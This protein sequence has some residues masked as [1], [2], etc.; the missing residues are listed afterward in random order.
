LVVVGAI[1]A[2]APGI[3]VRAEPAVDVPGHGEAAGDPPILTLDDAIAL[4]LEQN[5]DLRQ[6]AL[7]AEKADERLAATRSRFLPSFDLTV[8]D[9]RTIED[10]E[11][12]FPAGAFGDL[13]PVGPIPATD[14]D[15]V[16]PAGRMTY[17]VGSVTQ[18]LTGLRR[19]SLSTRARALDL[20]IRREDLRSRRQAI[21][22]SVRR[23]YY[24][25]L[26]TESALEATDEGLR[27][28][29]ELERVVAN[30]VEQRAA[31]QVDGLEVQARRAAE[32]YEAAV[33]RNSL[34]TFKEQLND[35]LGRDLDT[36]LAP[37][38][39]PEVV[40]EEADLAA[41]RARALAERAD[42][43]QARLRREQAEVERRLKR[44]DFV[45][46]LSLSFNY[47]STSNVEVLPHN[48]AS[49][50]LLLTWEPFDWGRRHRATREADH[51]L[52]QADSAL[53]QAE[54]QAAIDVGARIRALQEAR[55]L[56]EARRLAREA[57]RA[58]GQVTLD[59]YR[60][61]A[62]LLK[63][64]LEDQ[65]TLADAY[66]NYQQALAQAWTARAELERAF[67]R[68]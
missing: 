53:K 54:S 1:L 13:P 32:E 4:A 64:V 25:L 6:A 60:Q 38:P 23:T 39:V 16:A 29:R 26:R 34:V 12:R 40:P 41:A 61:K 36:P 5:R 51:G 66:R 28:L 17:V 57:A 48:L 45:P 58:R 37:E 24:D 2:A 68:E 14:T 46:D 8:L 44:W 11:F 47:V 67:G 49:V 18:P 59:R 27:F 10:V 50:G 21:I 7:E 22:E 65:E 20:E 62:A 56:L 55:V 43:R 63:D 42:L 3:P 35:L 31:L 19:V 52:E 15:V 30:L 33:L 9:G